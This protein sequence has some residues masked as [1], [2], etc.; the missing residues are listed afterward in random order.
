MNM[1]NITFFVVADLHYH[2]AI[3]EEKLKIQGF[4]YSNP[5]HKI[6]WL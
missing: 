2:F 1:K 4:D 6:V 3:V 5:L